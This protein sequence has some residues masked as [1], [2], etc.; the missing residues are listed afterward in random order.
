[1][2][3]RLGYVSNSSSSSFLLAY[4]DLKQFDCVNKTRGYGAL[5]PLLKM[6]NASEEEMVSFMRGHIGDCIYMCADKEW[7]NQHMAE[8]HGW[9]A[10]RY[11]WSLVEHMMKLGLDKSYA[12][13]VKELEDAISR[14]V[15]KFDHPTYNYDLDKFDDMENMLAL[16]IVDCLMKRY[17]RFA[18]VEFSDD[19]EF[20]SYLE[21]EFMPELISYSEE[22]GFLGASVSN[23]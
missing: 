12:P 17:S 3:T 18:V 4:D 2:K 5:L 7:N 9:L 8:N 20:G 15:Q 19:Y 16:V 23:H 10:R 6:G 13:V 22:R 21:H 11:E 14:H 1:M